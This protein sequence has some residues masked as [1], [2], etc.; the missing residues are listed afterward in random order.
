MTAKEY[1]AQ[2][3]KANSSINIKLEELESIKELL[4]KVTPTPCDGTG[5][6]GGG[7][8]DRMAERLAKKMDIEAEINS[9]IDKLVD[10]KMEARKKIEQLPESEMQVL[11]KRYFQFKKWEQIACEMAY[12]RQ[13]VCKIH[14]RGLQNLQKILEN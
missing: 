6:G 14:G 10:L 13:G 11:Y 7:A 8:T 9:E 1:L 3:K 4:L 12:T 2:I 5:G